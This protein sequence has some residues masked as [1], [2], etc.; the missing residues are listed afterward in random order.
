[1]DEKMEE[2]KKGKGFAITAVVLGIIGILASIIL[3]GEV[4]GVIGAVFGTIA[5]IKSKGKNKIKA[6]IRFANYRKR[7]KRKI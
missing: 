3:A 7:K 1:M 5:I 4:F 6:R 2:K